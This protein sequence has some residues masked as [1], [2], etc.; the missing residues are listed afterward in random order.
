[1]AV[2]RPE[3]DPGAGRVH[4][5]AA[6]GPGLDAAAEPGSD[7]GTPDRREG[8]LRAQVLL[9]GVDLLAPIALY[10]GLHAAGVGNVVALSAGA[11]PAG[12]GIT[13]Q[14]VRERRIDQPAVIVMTSLLVS[15]GLSFTTGSPRFLLAKD[16]WLTAGWG[17]WFLLSAGGSHPAAFLF[18]RPLLEGRRTFTAESW[19]R[20]WD[21]SSTFRR[22]WRTST[23]M[24]G[25][26]LLLD[27]GTR[28]AMAYTLPVALV[29]GLGGALY[30]ATFVVLQVV[31]NVYY[32]RSGL[33]T[34]LGATWDRMPRRPS[35]KLKRVSP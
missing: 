9:L 23:V 16:G 12:L 19:D 31:T 15:I 20:L 4:V 7:Q 30:P 33:W 34:V 3:G 11:I 26:G 24:W 25:L 29:P 1:M 21:R 22:I 28:V 27:A 35:G 14:F 8:H 10:Y 18:T 32:Y 17:L 6:I 5:D 13:V 2:R